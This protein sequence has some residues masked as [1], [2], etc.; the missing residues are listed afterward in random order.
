MVRGGVCKAGVVFLSTCGDDALVDA[1]TNA[2]TMAY[3]LKDYIGAV[4]GMG[5][6]QGGSTTMFVA[7]QPNGGIVTNPGS[8]P[9]NIYNG[10]FIIQ[11]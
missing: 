5:M 8:S 3:F 7:G 1:G 6:D 9:R 2:F 10:L 11:E 4:S